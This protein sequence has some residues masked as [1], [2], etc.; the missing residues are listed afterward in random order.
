MADSMIPYF[1]KDCRVFYSY[2]N[3]VLFLGATACRCFNEA[4]RLKN[5]KFKVWAEYGKCA[6]D[7]A[8]YISRVK[9]FGPENLNR[10][11]MKQ[12]R[13]RF[14]EQA[15]VCFESANNIVDA[16]KIWLNYYYLGKIAERSNILQALRYYELSDLH[17]AL[18]GATYPCRLG[19]YNSYYTRYEIEALEVHYRIHSSV[20]KY[21][22]RNSDKLSPKTLSQIMAF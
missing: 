19:Y 21:I 7:I 14:Y 22:R 11:E 10:E 18:T 2:T 8:S 12:H 20:L 4:I 17:L 15:R 3:E 6:Y 5:N 1:S 9:R 16:D 13:K